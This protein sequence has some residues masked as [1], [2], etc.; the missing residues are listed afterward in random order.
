METYGKMVKTIQNNSFSCEIHRNSSYFNRFSID[1]QRISS[2]RVGLL[3]VDEFNGTEAAA[4]QQAE[5]KASFRPR[6]PYMLYT[7]IH[8]YIPG[9]P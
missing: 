9:K 3:L 4:A 7:S 2:S 5:P 6:T 8:H 1:V